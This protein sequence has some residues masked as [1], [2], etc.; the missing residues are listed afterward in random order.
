MQSLIGLINTVI[1]L[2]IWCIIGYTVL[3]LLYSFQIINRHSEIANRVYNFLG[4]LIEPALRPLRRFIPMLGTI[5]ISPLVLIL[6]L[7]FFQSLIHEYA[8]RLLLG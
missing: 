2:Y 1:G 4:Q 6:G 7:Q 5:D 3:S 8:G